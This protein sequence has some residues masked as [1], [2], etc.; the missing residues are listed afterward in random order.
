MDKE[1]LE[2]FNKISKI[3]NVVIDEFVPEN[4]KR[5]VEPF[6]AQIFGQLWLNSEKT[7]KLY[8]MIK[9]IIEER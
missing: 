7:K 3:V 9:L 2:S 8:R 5:F 6:K 4:Y 1:F